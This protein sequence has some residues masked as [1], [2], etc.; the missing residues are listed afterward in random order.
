M[1]PVT[2]TVH[3]HCLTVVM[4]RVTFVVVMIEVSQSVMNF[5]QWHSSHITVRV[6]PSWFFALFLYFSDSQIRSSVFQWMDTFFAFVVFCISWDQE[7]N[8]WRP[9]FLR[10]RQFWSFT[11]NTAFD[12]RHT[13]HI[14]VGNKYETTTSS[15]IEIPSPTRP[16]T[17]FAS[18]TS[19]NIDIE[20]CFHIF[21]PTR[22][23]LFGGGW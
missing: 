13:K 4:T 15:L 7:W 12:W 11:A 21:F 2:V 9:R 3:C 20:W 17:L 1:S 23:V 10:S 16:G 6:S 5:Q 18:V 22:N 14:E 19:L 8:V